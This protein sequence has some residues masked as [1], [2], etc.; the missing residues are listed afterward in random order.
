MAEMFAITIGDDLIVDKY[1]DNYS[2]NI[3]ERYAT[4]TNF[5][6]ISGKSM[7]KYL[8]DRRELS[9]NFEPMETSQLNQLVKAIK[10]HKNDIPIEYNDPQF[11]NITKRFS[12]HTLPAATYFV[13]DDNRKFWT[14][15]TVVFVETD[16]SASANDEDDGSEKWKYEIQID[17]AGSYNEDEISNNTSISISAG[18]NGWS[19]GQCCSSTITGELLYKGNELSV[20]KNAVLTLYCSKEINFK[21]VENYRYK[22]FINS[23]NVENKSIIHFSAVD[24]IAFVDNNYPMENGAKISSHIKAAE[25]VINELAKIKITINQP[26]FSEQFKIINQSGWN[27]RTLLNYASVYGAANYTALFNLNKV[28]SNNIEISAIDTS[29]TLSVSQD[30]YSNLSVGM[31]GAKIEQIRVSQTDI[32]DPILEEGMTYDDFGIYYLSNETNQKANVLNLV[33]PWVDETI[34]KVSSLSNKI[35]ESY[36]TEFSCDNVKVNELYPP[37]V[38]IN[39]EGFDDNVYTFYI[40]NASYKLTTIGIYASIS[41]DTKSLSDFE[42]IGKT[43]TELKT[44]VALN[45]GY[46]SGFISQE[47]GIYWDDNAV[48]EMINSG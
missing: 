48:T 21:I 23:F 6:S 15:P 38:K 33:C 32:Q 43:E 20:K 24:A 25:T 7:N 41:G 16:E 4:D 42:Y 19:I 31:L 17:G 12:C 36:G 34:K 11:G 14:I 18:S 26:A 9:V 8:G 2:V 35:G 28:S 46:Q 13:A 3:I 27:I 37:Y 44:K 30:N 47:N 29:K 5:T 45:M 40:S 39:F 1:L 22:W 10:K